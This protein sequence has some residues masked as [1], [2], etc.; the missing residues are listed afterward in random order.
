MSESFAMPSIPARILGQMGDDESRAIYRALISMPNFFDDRSRMR[1]AAIAIDS[2]LKH[3]LAYEA[4]SIVDL[5][6]R[7][8]VDFERLILYPAGNFAYYLVYL[9]RLF[10]ISPDLFCDKSPEKQAAYFCGVP[11]VSIEEAM[12]RGSGSAV[13][14]A[15]FDSH[16]AINQEA[17]ARRF[18]EIFAGVFQNS[19]MGKLRKEYFF[20]PFLSPI[21]DE[22]YLDTGIGSDWGT[23]S[24]FIAFT[25]G[26]Y[27]KIY[28]FEASPVAYESLMSRDPRYRDVTILPLG[29]G[30]AAKTEKHHLQDSGQLCC[31]LKG[32]T[33]VKMAAIDDVVGDEPVTFIKMDIEG[34]EVDALKGAQNTIRRNRPVLAICIYHRPGDPVEIPVLINTLAPGYEFYVR[35]YSSYVFETVLFAV[36]PERRRA[37][38]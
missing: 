11:V 38:V 14:M 8:G 20:E 23:I 29:A 33:E 18:S 19:S 3:S 21:A 27:R 7:Y 34:A 16:A 24:D 22:I 31:N 13:L 5:I 26:R 1:I 10:G 4:Y 28:G 25:G 37:T 2:I 30:S 36:P 17:K 32:D 6:K 35:H 15:G 9:L 12:K